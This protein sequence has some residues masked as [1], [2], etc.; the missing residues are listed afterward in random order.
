VTGLSP[1]HR[2]VGLEICSVE[3]GS[4][5][6]ELATRPEMANSISVVHGGLLAF[7]ADSAMGAA[8]RGLIPEGSSHVSFDLKLSFVSP[9]RIGERLRAVAKVLHSGRR[10]KVAECRV[11]V[12]ERLV[13]TATA[14]FLVRDPAP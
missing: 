10:T 14:T 12:G 2:W 6:L 11:S 9:V 4:A 8:V 3:P 5:E 7:L 1:A 13:A